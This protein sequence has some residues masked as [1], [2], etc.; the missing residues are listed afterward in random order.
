MIDKYGK[1]GIFSNQIAP[2]QVKMA[3]ISRLIIFI[4]EFILEIKTEKI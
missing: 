1:F 2:F 3:E 4:E